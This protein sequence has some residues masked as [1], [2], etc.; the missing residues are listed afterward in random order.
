M[1]IIPQGTSEMEETAAA[2]RV[3]QLDGDGTGMVKECFAQN[4]IR[5]R[6]AFLTTDLCWSLWVEVG[7]IIFYN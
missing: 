7:D 6:I 4:E 2:M 3:I 5:N 1:P